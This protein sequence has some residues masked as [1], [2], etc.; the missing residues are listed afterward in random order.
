MYLPQYSYYLIV[1][2]YCKDDR[3]KEFFSFPDDD[4]LDE[5][6]ARQFDLDLTKDNFMKIGDKVIYF[7]NDNIKSD[8]LML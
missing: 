8:I 1:F 7:S 4:I 3:D 5:E 6:P 2:K